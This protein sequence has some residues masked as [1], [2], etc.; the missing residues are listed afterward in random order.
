MIERTYQ[1]PNPQSESSAKPRRHPLKFLVRFV[2]SKLP[3]RRVVTFGVIVVLGLI[4][5]W[6]YQTE[7][8]SVDANPFS[9]TITTGSKFPL[10]YPTVL[11]A[12]YRIV[13]HSAYKPQ[14]YVVLFKL[15]GPSGATL[16]CSEEARSASFNLGGYYTSFANYK[17]VAVSDGSVIYGTRSGNEI[18]SRANNSTWVLCNTTAAIPS[19][20][21]I[22]MLKSITPAS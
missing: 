1:A 13:P 22:N 5:Y 8:W 20:Q 9:A 6:L 15:A 3:V 19:S 18:V 14:F 21:L 2:R 4:G 17:A 16:F 7:P 12:G 10:Y 11:P